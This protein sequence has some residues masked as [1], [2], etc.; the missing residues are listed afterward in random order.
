[1]VTLED[2]I[3]A[4]GGTDAEG[5]EGQKQH[6]V[7][8]VGQDPSPVPDHTD[9]EN[10]DRQS[11]DRVGGQDQKADIRRRLGKG[12]DTEIVRS[13]V[14]SEHKGHLLPGMGNGV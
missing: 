4:P 12:L 10:K 5:D 9:K 1:M 2:A 13:G 3:Q 14:S 7:P 8:S 11:Q 6:Q